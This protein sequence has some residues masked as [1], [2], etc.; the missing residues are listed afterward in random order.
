[1]KCTIIVKAPKNNACQ[2]W[3][4][5]VKYMAEDMH[6]SLY[7]PLFVHTDFRKKGH[8]VNPG[9]VQSL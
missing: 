9:Q 6:I 5:F 8:P 3:C 1:M 4:S 7:F 2:T